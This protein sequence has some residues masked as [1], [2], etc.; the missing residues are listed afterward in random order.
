MQYE[1]AGRDEDGQN[2]QDQDA[3][4]NEESHVEDLEGERGQSEDQAAGN[5]NE[6]EIRTESSLDVE[7]TMIKRRITDTSTIDKDSICIDGLNNEEK[8]IK[9]DQPAGFG[10]RVITSLR[11]FIEHLQQPQVNILTLYIFGSEAAIL[12]ECER[13][14]NLDTFVIHPYNTLRSY[15]IMYM[16]VLTFANLII[17]PL[18]I[19]FFDKDQ[20]LKTIGWRTFSFVSDILYLVD[21]IINFRVGFFNEDREVV[22]LNPKDIAMRYIKTWLLIDLAAA[23]PLD[24]IL[25]LIKIA[26]FYSFTSYTFSKFLRFLYFGRMISLVQHLQVSSMMRRF[27]EWELATDLNLEPIHLI[28]RTFSVCF[29]IL[30]ICHWNG[31][32]Q[33]FIPMIEGF[34]ENSWVVKANL[35][36]AWW[37]DQ[38]SA[39]VFRAISHTL[40]N[41]YGTGGLPT[42][43]TEVAVTVVSMISGALM[44]TIM[45]ANVAA[46]VLNADVP[47]RI[48]REKLCQ[49]EEYT[50][51]R[52]LP[53]ELRMKISNYYKERFNG[54]WFDQ[55]GI[56][57]EM[58]EYLKE[59]V[60]TFIC[61]GLVQNVPMFQNAD[62]NFVKGII[63]N[64]NYEVFMKD[65]VII[66]EGAAGDRMFFIES[67]IV[68]IETTYY[69]KHLSNGAYF[70]EICLLTKGY[71]KATVRALTLCKLYSLSAEKFNNLLK[72][73]PSARGE[74]LLVVSKRQ[75]ALKSA[76]DRWRPG[77]LS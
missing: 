68:S 44:H 31:C 37:A 66:R 23:F 14:K 46:M 29:I 24:S 33:F 57:S 77:G 52:R 65:D 71:R 63:T 72:L 10:R 55:E 15:Y 50:K 19:T 45:V 53:R 17:T 54:K 26:G 60:L 58:T 59:D 47:G 75:R 61:R 22:N 27:K 76:I 69:Q 3:G 9:I 1:Y 49:V 64:L 21:I 48:Y 5:D 25:F 20:G 13:A 40:G 70:G 43:L 34:P 39:G 8:L 42:E 32:I 41:S 36:E 74:I 16:L 62:S 12:K 7:V 6:R 18:G 56:L 4:K 35:T 11:N 51:N 38:Y 67:G 30:V 73:F 2:V 28:L